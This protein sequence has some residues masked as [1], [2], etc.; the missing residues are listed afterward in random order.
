MRLYRHSR[1]YTWCLKVWWPW[2]YARYDRI[3]PNLKLFDKLLA[4]TL[5]L[6]RERM[7]EAMYNP[8]PLITYIQQ[9]KYVMPIH[10]QEQQK[11]KS[12]RHDK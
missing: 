4:K 5:G 10:Y 9:H 2:H 6:Y 7:I 1:F 3:Q 12:R 11:K 8:S